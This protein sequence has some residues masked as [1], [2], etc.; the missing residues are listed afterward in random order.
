MGF[1]TLFSKSAPKLLQLPSGSLTVDRTGDILVTTVP[2]NFPAELLTEIG[3]RIVTAFREAHAAQLP[4]SELTV[5]YP[6]LKITAREL[7]GG[8]IIF[9]LPKTPYAPSA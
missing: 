1:L 2:S 6:T 7:R 3:N 5:N 8:A 9:L 4:L